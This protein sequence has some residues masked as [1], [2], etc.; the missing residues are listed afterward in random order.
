[1]GNKKWFILTRDNIQLRIAC[2]M[3]KQAGES[4]L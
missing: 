2:E 1:M 4:F 3:R